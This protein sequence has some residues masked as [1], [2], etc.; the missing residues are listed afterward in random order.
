MGPGPVGMATA[1]PDGW[2][3]YP[4]FSGELSMGLGLDICVPAR[5]WDSLPCALCWAEAEKP[6]LDMRAGGWHCPQ[7]APRGHSSC[8][9]RDWPIAGTQS[10]TADLSPFNRAGLGW[11]VLFSGRL[12]NFI[13][14][15]CLHSI[16]N[17]FLIALSLKKCRAK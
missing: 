16:P 3:A 1:G 4:H 17:R 11:F 8:D 9:S 7:Q 5:Q 10:T 14:K 2:S 15:I 12:L 6:A 13:L